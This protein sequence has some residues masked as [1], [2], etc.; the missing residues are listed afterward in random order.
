MAVAGRKTGKYEHSPREIMKEYHHDLWDCA[1]L[2]TPKLVEIQNKLVELLPICKENL[3]NS[4]EELE[5]QEAQCNLSDHIHMR[6]L[7]EF[8]GELW[9]SIDNQC[10][11]LARKHRDDD[12]Y[13]EKDAE[14]ALCQLLDAISSFPFEDVLKDNVAGIL[15]FN[16]NYLHKCF[17]QWVGNTR[18]ESWRCDVLGGIREH[19]LQCDWLWRDAVNDTIPVRPNIGEL[20]PGQ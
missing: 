14:A 16:E 17:R 8:A 19:G 7:F 9:K 6:L 10:Y 2:I 11:D 13:G 20:L 1:N 12:G 4:F 3:P 15:R 18:F 5:E